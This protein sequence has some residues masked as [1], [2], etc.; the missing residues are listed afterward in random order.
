LDKTNREIWKEVL[1]KIENLNNNVLELEKLISELPILS[2]EELL[3]KIHEDLLMKNIT[4][5]EQNRSQKEIYKHKTEKKS[6]LTQSLI[7]KTISDIKNTPVKKVFF[8]KKFLN[9]F[10]DISG[11][12]KEVLLND[13]T[14]SDI[15][16]LSEKMES[17]I[18]TFKL[19]ETEDYF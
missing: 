8:L 12:D 2:R 17:L 3:Q 16:N 10:S 4:Y 15:N 14:R 18:K 5:R 9:K 13:L 7:D 1:L 11:S 6:K 19:K